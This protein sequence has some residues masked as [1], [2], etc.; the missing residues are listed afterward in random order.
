MNET[1]KEISDWS[2]DYKIPNHTYFLN[3]AGKLVAYIKEGTDDIIHLKT[4]IFF[5]KRYRKF[6]K[7]KDKSIDIPKEKNVRSFNV[8]S[9][10][11]E[12]IVSLEN[13]TK[14]TC[15]CTGFTYRGKCKHIEAVKNKL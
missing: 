13:N 9:K 3:R 15:T 1:L 5:D 14:F 8:K 2:C 11:N 4:P 6:I 10:D 12:Y 7:I